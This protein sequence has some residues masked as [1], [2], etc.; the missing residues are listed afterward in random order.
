MALRHAQALEPIDVQPL[1][2]RLA[3]SVTTSLIKS[4]NLQL[5]RVVLRAGEHLPEHHVRGEITLQCLEGQ[6]QIS[7]PTHELALSPG[8][9]VLLP[10]GEA[11]A[12]HALSDT[13]MLVTISLATPPA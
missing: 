10:E 5:M 3:Q 13:S 6:A 4:R 7:T 8:Q 2:E 1:R 12:V 9:V 11:H